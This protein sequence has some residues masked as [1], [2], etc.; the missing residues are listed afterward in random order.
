MR[1]I[2]PGDIDSEKDYLLIGYKNR[3]NQFDIAKLKISLISSYYVPN[4]TI[5][6]LTSKLS[7]LQEFLSG[8]LTQLSDLGDKMTVM[9]LSAYCSRTKLDEMIDERTFNES[10]NFMDYLVKNFKTRNEVIDITSLENAGK[11]LNVAVNKI[12]TM[13]NTAF[14]LKEKK[15]ED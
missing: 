6:M 14:K 15:E 12:W 8:A 7:L 4:D 13:F 2:T 1:Y 9:E 5:S 10:K 11:P 3:F